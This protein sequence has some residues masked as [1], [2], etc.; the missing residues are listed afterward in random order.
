MF[1]RSVLWGWLAVA[2]NLVVG[3]LLSPIIIR[4]LGA[5]QYGVWVL[6]FSLLDYMRV[7]DF[8]FRSAVLNGSARFRARGDW[9][10]VSRVLVTST[11]YFVCIFGACML[12]VIASRS[13]L[14]GA[15][16]V[17]DSMR[18]TAPTLIVLIAIAVTI[19]LSFSPLTAVLEAFQRFDVVN[20]AYIGSLLFRSTASLVVLFAGYGLVEMAWI[21]LLAQVGESVAIVIGLRRVAPQ[22][23]W[24]PSLIQRDVFMGLFQYGRFSALI[25]ASNL[26]T[27]NAPATVLGLLRSAAEV[28]YFALPFRLLMYSAEGLMK[29][30]DVTASVTAA[31]DE[32]GDKSKVWRLAVVTNRQCF[33]LFMPLAIFLGVYGTPLLR[34]WVTPEMAE[35][36]GPLFPILLVSFLFATSGQYNAGGVLFGQG[37]HA[38][39]AYGTVVEAVANIVLLLMF[40]PTYGVVGAAWVSSSVLLAIRGVYLAGALCWQNGFPFGEYL[41]AVYAHG[42]ATGLPVLALALVL[43]QYVWPGENWTDLILAGGTLFAIYFSLAFFSVLEAEHRYQFT[44]RLVPRFLG[45]W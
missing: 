43:R 31:L 35:N 37:R 33:A 28:A 38:V 21:V 16:D 22:L 15:I 29:V 44:H 42:V 36:S 26:V 39:F 10:G 27:V 13:V 17:S 8:G 19:R 32:T 18:P 3:V 23:T 12:A 7:L 5:E 25:A 4:K 24:A 45:R 1:L 30:A 40:V 20:A 14:L 9:T 41:W 11:T 2:L 6:L 34:L